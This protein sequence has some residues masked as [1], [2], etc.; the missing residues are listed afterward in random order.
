MSISLYTI[1]SGLRA[2]QK[3]IRANAQNIANLNTNN[4]KAVKV[5]PVEGDNGGVDVHITRDESPGAPL[6]PGVGE[7]G[8]ETSN[9][10]I[11]REM[12]GL[13]TNINSVRANLNALERSDN[14]LGSLLDIM[15]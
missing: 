15:A 10:D 7:V 4:Y 8:D 11:G 9:V 1:N 13:M 12:V 2:F 5:T 6:P 14:T 3:S